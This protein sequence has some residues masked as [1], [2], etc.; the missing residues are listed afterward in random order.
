MWWL[1]SNSFI[2]NL[3]QCIGPAATKVESSFR[4]LSKR[5]RPEKFFFILIIY[6]TRQYVNHKI[7]SRY[8]ESKIIINFVINK[9][10]GKET[11]RIEGSACA[12]KPT[13]NVLFV[14]KFGSKMNK[15]KIS[16]RF[17]IILVE[18]QFQQWKVYNPRAGEQQCAEI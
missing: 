2:R 8:N 4:F 7:F 9:N 10:K 13:W 14:C 17:N 6:I 1:S 12:L 5:I 11:L 18:N 15:N 16:N 3:C